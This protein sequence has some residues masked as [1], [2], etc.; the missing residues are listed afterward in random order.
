ML[1]ILICIGLMDFVWLGLIASDLYQEAMSG[2]IRKEVILWPWFV[3]YFMY[4]AIIFVLAVVANR[5]KPAYYAAIDGILLGMAGYGV[6]NLTNYSLIE[7]FPFYIAVI[8]FIWG[9]FLTGTSAV[10]GWIGFQKMRKDTN[11]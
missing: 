10:A 4:G 3:F 9:V 6:Y 1:A 7:G 2:L 11:L 5:D 8:D